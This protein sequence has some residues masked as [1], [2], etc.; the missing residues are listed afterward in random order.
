MTGA[1]STKMQQLAT[2]LRRIS[3]AHTGSCT[4]AV[5]DLATGE[6]VGHD[7]GTV[8]PTA[9]LIKTPILVTLYQAVHDG[10]FR[11]DD[12]ARYEERHRSLGS[13]VLSKMSFGV[14]MTVRDAATLMMIISDNSATNMCIDMVGLDAINAQMERLGLKNTRI[15]CRLGDRSAGLDPRKMNVSAAADMCA[16]F[17]LIGHHEAVSVDASEDM[18]RIMRRSDYRHELSRELPWNEMNMLP[19][20]PRSAWVAEK[21][22]AFLNGARTG[23]AVMHGPS[24]E[25]AMAAFCEGGSGSGG[26]GRESEGNVTLGALGK[27]AWDAL[28]G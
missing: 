2:H 8:M 13:G 27:A 15:F 9:S 11:L 19:P 22:G 10:R 28:A 24:G 1:T 26:A 12:R 6:H 7:E 17:A 14:E 16:L 20:D 5:T 21:G 25:F 3:D 4:W 23:G 18:L